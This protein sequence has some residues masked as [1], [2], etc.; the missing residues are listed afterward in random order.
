MIQEFKIGDRVRTKR[1]KNVSRKNLVIEKVKGVAEYYGKYNVL[2]RDL[3][4]KNS[5]AH[6]WARARF[7]KLKPG[8]YLLYEVEELEKVS[9]EPCFEN[10]I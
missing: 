7:L 3:N 5:N 8:Y 9:Y 10:L 4:S 6:Q 2:C 1:G